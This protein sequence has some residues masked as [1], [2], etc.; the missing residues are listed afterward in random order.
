MITSPTMAY[1]HGACIEISFSK[2]L[3]IW[4]LISCRSSYAVK[5]HTSA[6]KSLHG[7]DDRPKVER[8]ASWVFG[9]ESPELE[10][11]ISAENT[12]TRMFQDKFN[13]AYDSVLKEF[14]PLRDAWDGLKSAYTLAWTGFYEGFGGLFLEYPWEGFARDGVFG[15]VAGTTAGIVHFT[16]LTTTGIAAGL[17]QAVRGIER[18]F[19]A[20]QATRE[21]KLWHDV[22]K[23]WFYY[24]LDHE[25]TTIEADA[26]SHKPS[27]R[28]L[29]RKVKNKRFYELLGVPVDASTSDI[30]KAYYLK[31]LTVH[32]DKSSESEAVE[33]FR[34]LN[35]AYR[36]LVTKETRQMYDS[37]GI[38]F[39]DRAPSE[40]SARVDPYTFFSVL[41]GTGVVEPYVGDL[42]IAS[43]VDNTL[44]LT[45]RA[46]TVSIGDS[47]YASPQQLRRQIEIA[48]HLRYRIQNYTDGTMS[49]EEFEFSCR[50]ET[51]SLAIALEDSVQAEYLLKSISS[52][53]MGAV[54]EYSWTKSL[55]ALSNTYDTAKNIK[56]VYDLEREI[57]LAVRG[58]NITMQ[59]DNAQSAED[60]SAPGHGDI[61]SLLMHL[62][63][64]KLL[65]LVWK[66]NVNDITTTVREASKRV[67]DD[68][69][70]DNELRSK[71]AMALNILGREFAS[72]IRTRQEIHRKD[73][74][75]FPD[76]DTI[77]RNVRNA[78]I[79]SVVT[80]MLV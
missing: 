58:A 13:A 27:N 40:E 76:S 26:W 23:E 69:A 25:A 16:S 45:E 52:G 61:D 21:G 2:K 33:H 71:R 36:T 24:S 80:D 30:K 62:A 28:R 1:V 37:H 67:I 47:N 44:H 73:G 35:T 46:E 54:A 7:D 31:A 41:F 18:T 42:A 79:E 9:D 77:H 32:P 49:Q 53:M 8:L 56:V 5:I 4:L 55:A 48:S 3:V 12:I 6:R 75:V 29:R 70:S 78:L 15:F 64:P 65:K 51:E 34:A 39:A 57:K 43:I 14:L 59:Q 72:A 68:S 11:T 74:W 19:V 17:Y 60:C 50:A 20:M 66:F 63:V 10:E 22:R 38:C